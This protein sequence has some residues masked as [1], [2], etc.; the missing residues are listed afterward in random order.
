MGVTIHYQL[1]LSSTSISDA[2]KVL[3]KLRSLALELPFAK[4]IDLFELQGN[5]CTFD[6]NKDLGRIIVPGRS[7]IVLRNF[8]V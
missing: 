3:K 5:D 7:I 1:G 2:K 8:H 6:Y 4:V